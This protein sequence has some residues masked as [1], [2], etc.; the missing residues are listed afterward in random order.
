MSLIKPNL[1]NPTTIKIAQRS[2]A[3][4]RMDHNRRGPVNRVVKDTTFEIKCQIDWSISDEKSAPMNTNVGLD[5]QERG[6]A[7]MRTE[8][9][10]ALGKTLKTND[11]IVQ[12]ENLEVNF[13]ILRLEYGSHYAG[14]FR[15]VKVHFHD[16]KGQDG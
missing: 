7:I 3:N 6:Y 1:L 2:D 14:K 5:E 16:R 13:Y 10:E 12:I 8:D 15:L 4:T 11:R 9:L